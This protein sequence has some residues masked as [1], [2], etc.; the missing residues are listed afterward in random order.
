MKEE[1]GALQC[2]REEHIERKRGPTP[3]SITPL[4]I[5]HRE[6][7]SPQ[8]PQKKKKQKKKKNYL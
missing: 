5:P 8:G 2:A 1:G 7:K 6:P 4:R 3:R